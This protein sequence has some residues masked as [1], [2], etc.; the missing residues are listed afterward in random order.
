MARLALLVPGDGLGEQIRSQALERARAVGPVETARELDVPLNTVKSWMKRERDRGWRDAP[1]ESLS[2]S[3]DG[4]AGE[5]A[6]ALVDQLKVIGVEAAAAAHAAI[7]KGQA[8]QAKHFVVSVEIAIDHLHRVEN[9][10]RR[11]ENA[12][13][14]SEVRRRLAA[15]EEEEDDDG[16]E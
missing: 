15:D 14:R 10:K 4:S 5:V 1:A 2:V 12:A 3:T 8:A 13:L 7:A 11:R 6:E 9:R 16:E